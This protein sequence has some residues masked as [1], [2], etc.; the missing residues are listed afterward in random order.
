MSQRTEFFFVGAHVLPAIMLASSGTD[1]AAAAVLSYLALL[2]MSL[3][4]AMGDMPERQPVRIKSD[5]EQDIR[6]RR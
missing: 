6:H 4:S 3:M 5:D 1:A 2:G